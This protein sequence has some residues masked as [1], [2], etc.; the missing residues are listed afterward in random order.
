M[1]APRIAAPS[2]PPTIRNAWRTPEETPLVGTVQV[3]LIGDTDEAGSWINGLHGLLA[4]VVFLL[5]VVLAQ[6]GMCS[7]RRV[8]EPT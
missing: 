8:A 4:L 2:T 1:T 3:F 6:A 5:A 7:L